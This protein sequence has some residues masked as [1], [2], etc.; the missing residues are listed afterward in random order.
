[1]K[2]KLF[3]LKLKRLIQL[4]KETHNYKKLAVVSFVLTSNTVDEIGIK[5]GMRP[6]EKNSGEKIFEYMELVNKVF[7]VNF[8]V[9]VF[10]PELIDVL[11]RIELLF[12]KKEGELRLEYV[13]EIFEIYYELRKLDVP[14]LHDNINSEIIDK[15]RTISLFSFLSG[16]QNAKRK[17]EDLF[18]PILL[19]KF[20]EEE[21]ALQ[22][23]LNKQFDKNTFEKILQ[24]K[25]IRKSIEQ[26]K[27]GKIVISGSLKDNI[28]YKQSKEQV[29]QFLVIGI[30]ILFAMVGS[31]SLI[32]A[33]MYGFLSVAISYNLLVCF[34]AIVVLY[35]VNKTY[36]GNR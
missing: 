9:N 14:N 24:L 18:N 29:G 11:K 5:L 1:M 36:F 20:K 35:F 28:S 7:R 34:G 10:R 12:M 4:C 30:I 21:K 15:N 19:H 32:E 26:K 23:Q 13:K 17:K 2:E 31:V 33:L 3:D 25:T 27:G 6:R 8:S 22:Y 16:G